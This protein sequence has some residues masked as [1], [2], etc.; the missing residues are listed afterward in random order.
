MPDSSFAA[1]LAFPF[2]GSTVTITTL[3]D[4]WAQDLIAVTFQE[5]LANDIYLQDINAYKV[6]P[7]DGGTPVDV[8]EVQTGNDASATTVWLVVTAPQIGKTYQI[9]FQNLYAITGLVITPNPCNFIGRTTKED[10]II[11]SRPQ[12][13]DMR[14]NSNIRKLLQAIGRQ[15]DLIGGS[16]SDYFTSP[17]PTPHVVTVV[18]TPNPATVVVNGSQT[19]NALVD[20]GVGPQDCTWFVNDIP[21]G[22][23]TVGQLTILSPSSVK[24]T[25]PALVP[26]P[27]TVTLKAVSNI[28]GVLGTAAITVTP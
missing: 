26:S 19:F 1:P 15:D 27:A 18:V 7:L 8:V 13:Y 12:M 23:S 6:T 2:G 3:C 5:P 22:N 11:N 24:Y 20:G 16:R 28:W 14:P 17:L 21:L 10:A 25:A 4:V 9:T